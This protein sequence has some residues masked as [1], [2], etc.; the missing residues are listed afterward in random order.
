VTPDVRAPDRFVAV[1]IL[2]AVPTFPPKIQ[3]LGVS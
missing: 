1:S 3:R 2:G